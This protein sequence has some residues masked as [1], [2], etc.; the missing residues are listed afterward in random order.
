MQ[1]AIIADIHD[2][3][4]NLEKCLNWCQQNSITRL[5]CLGDLTTSETLNFLATNFRGEIFMISGNGE[6]YAAAELS[7]YPHIHFYGQTGLINLDGLTIGLVHEKWRLK[8]LLADHPEEFAFLFYG[9]SHMPSLEKTGATIIANP[10][11]LAG[12]F[13]QATFATLDTTTSRLELKILAE[14]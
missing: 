5:L 11:N 13:Y 6:I 2:N 12:T 14:L 8:K 1:L 10:G 4:A 9:H 7:A 3:L